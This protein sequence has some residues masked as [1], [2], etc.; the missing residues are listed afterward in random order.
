[1]GEAYLMKRGGVGSGIA[2]SGYAMICAKIP[3]GCTCV[4]A[5]GAERITAENV[6]GIVAY[7]VSSSGAWTV[8]ITDGVRGRTGLMAI[9]GQGEVRAIQMSFPSAPAV[10]EA[11]TILS[12][13]SGL[14]S[15]Y[16]LSGSAAMSGNAIRENGSGGFWLEPAVDLSAYS[17]L[18]ITGYLRSAGAERSRICLGS[19]GAKGFDSAQIP[20]MT[21]VWMGGVDSLYTA[22]LSITPLTG[23]YYI[24]SS[25]VGNNL[26]ITSITLS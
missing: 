17:T 4:C 24:G 25:A 15:G 1:M 13:Q 5:K 19:T 26:E 8:T 12:A 16:T 6:P 2:L 18:T 11:G 7:A 9:S 20:D 10:S 23:A 14:K 22:S 21:A 3:V